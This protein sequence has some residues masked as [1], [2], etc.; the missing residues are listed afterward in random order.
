MPQPTTRTVII[1]AR[2]EHEG[3]HSREVTLQWTCPVCGGVRGEPFAT[4][5][6]DGSRRLYVHGWINPCGH[7]DNY[8]AVR[9]EA[10]AVE[11]VR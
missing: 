9:K 7:I 8:D 5:S 2:A 11:A 10:D 6:Y 4:W 3:F 1:P